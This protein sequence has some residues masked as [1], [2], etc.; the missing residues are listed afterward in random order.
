MEKAV[1]VQWSL[2]STLPKP[3]APQMGAFF[4]KKGPAPAATA[5]DALGGKRGK[6]RL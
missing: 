5:A 2:S 1:P 4:S 6:S 3:T